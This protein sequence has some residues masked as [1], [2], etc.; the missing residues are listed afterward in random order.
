M[1]EGHDAGVSFRT[2]HDPVHR[3]TC[4]VVSNTSEGAWPLVRSLNSLL[5]T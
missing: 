2:T 1:I 4:T 5:D 3:V